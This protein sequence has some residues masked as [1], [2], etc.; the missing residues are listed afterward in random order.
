MAESIGERAD[1]LAQGEPLQPSG[2][3]S[4]RAVVGAGDLAIDGGVRI[5]IVAEVH[6]EQCAVA[7]GFTAVEGPEEISGAPTFTLVETRRDV[8]VGFGDVGAGRRY[9]VGR[10]GCAIAL[11]RC[12]DG[13]ACFAIGVLLDYRTIG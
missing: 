9:T 11:E 1:R 10:D 7:E 3:N 8:P 4:R 12:P 6:D 13:L 5:G 2:W